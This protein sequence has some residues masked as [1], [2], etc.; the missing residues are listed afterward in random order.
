M[1]LEYISTFYADIANVE[2]YLEEYPQKAKRIFREMDNKLSNLIDNPELYPIYEDFP[3]FRRIVVEDYLVFYAINERANIIEVHRLINGK[4][5]VPKQL[6]VVES[7][8]ESIAQEIVGF[9]MVD[10]NL[11]LE[12]AMKLLYNSELFDKINDEET[13]LYLEGAAYVYELL[14]DELNA[15]GSI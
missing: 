13:G 14:K 5:D 1:K 8:A 2:S 7:L 10:N 6:S 9:L 11:E 12:E 15:K 3:V 4:M